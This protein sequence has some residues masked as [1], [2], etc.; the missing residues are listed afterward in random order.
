M[1]NHTFIEGL[2]PEPKNLTGDLAKALKIKSCS[3]VRNSIG[4]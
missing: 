2:S 3:F 1:E 4:E